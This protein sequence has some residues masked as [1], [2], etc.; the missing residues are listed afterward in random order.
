MAFDTTDK[1][2]NDFYSVFLFFLVS[3][4]PKQKSESFAK[5]FT[6]WLR[7]DTK[8]QPIS[9]PSQVD[10][11]LV[12]LLFGSGDLCSVS[13]LQVHCRVCW[14]FLFVDRSVRPFVRSF[15]RWDFSFLPYHSPATPFFLSAY[16]CYLYLSSG[17]N[18]LWRLPLHCCDDMIAN[19][20]FKI[21]S[22]FFS[23]EAVLD[24]LVVG[25]AGKSFAC[26]CI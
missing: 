7:Q 22:I 3:A 19:Y 4:S 14:S 12:E 13:R 1:N 5:T 10:R 9:R 26:I 6:S 18:F 16:L 17:L 15:F 11:A 24:L 8:A 25:D 21:C 23:D 20:S 2:F